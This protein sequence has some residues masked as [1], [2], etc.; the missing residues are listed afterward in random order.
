VIDGCAIHWRLLNLVA[1]STLRE[2]EVDFSA[3]LQ[4]EVG[5]PK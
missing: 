2:I 1:T 4:S 3:T 5:L